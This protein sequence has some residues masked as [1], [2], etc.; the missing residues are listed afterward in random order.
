[1]QDE[2]KSN[3]QS[4]KKSSFQRNISRQK[5]RIGLVLILVSLFVG[6]IFL[7]I[8]HDADS[9]R[10]AGEAYIR[11]FLSG[12]LDKEPNDLTDED[13]AKLTYFHMRYPSGEPFDLTLFE[14]FTGL[15][16]FIFIEFLIPLNKPVVPKWKLLLA[17][18]GII[19]L[20]IEGYFDLKPIRK[21]TN[22]QEIHLDGLMIAD[23]KPFA[24][25]INL[26]KLT[27]SRTRV[28]DLTP[29]KNLINLQELHIS[30]SPVSNLE[31]VKDLINL[32]V[33]QIVSTKVSDLK[34]I[35]NLTN[36]EKLDIRSNPISSLEP[37]KGLKNLKYIDISL[38]NN[39]T[40]NQIEELR[41]IF[42]SAEI[43]ISGVRR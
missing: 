26:K 22:L 32:K 36:L 9:K 6:S 35:K 38:I 37:I 13:F 8:K 3:I 2:K 31:P 34:P 29:I 27:L 19:D 12:R 39:I 16:T 30:N 15:Q 28:D 4:G 43:I 42:P 33:L 14:K 17:K 21:L 24:K 1:M 5:Y 25:L 20:E 18:L 23:I 41:E 7:V 11:Q 40:D 10:K